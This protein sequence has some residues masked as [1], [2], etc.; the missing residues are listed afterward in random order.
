LI[1]PVDPRALPLD[2]TI[3][4]VITTYQSA[5][6]LVRALDSVERQT[7]RPTE[8]LVCDDGS[9]DETAS[10]ALARPGVRLLSLPHSGIVGISRNEGIAEATGEWIAF[11]DAD[12]E[13]VADHLKRFLDTLRRER[14]GFDLFGGNAVRVDAHEGESPL[15]IGRGRSSSGPVALEDFLRKRPIVTSSAVARR[16]AVLEAGGFAEEL[17]AVSAE[18]FDLWYRMV[19]RGG[20][21]FDDAA[22]V[23]YSVNEDGLTRQGGGLGSREA[24]IHVLRKNLAL[25]RA[26]GER[27]LLHRELVTD[28]IQLARA[29][30][31]LDRPATAVRS[32]TRVLREG[33]SAVARVA[34][35]AAVHRLRGA[36]RTALV[37]TVGASVLVSLLGLARQ[38]VLANIL[39]PTGIADLSLLLSI[40][41]P[42]STLALWPMLSF[43]GPLN[44][45][46]ETERRRYLKTAAMVCLLGFLA[47]AAL[48][49]I[50][51]YSTHVLHYPLGT[52]NGFNA[53]IVFAL[54]MVGIGY[55]TSAL[56]Y[57]GQLRRWRRIT[58]VVATAQLTLVVTAAWMWGRDGAVWSFASST[59]IIGAWLLLKPLVTSPR[60][61]FRLP[62]RWLAISLANGLVSM[63][64][65]G[66][67][68]TLRQASAAL[69]LTQ[70]AYFQASLSIIGAI[71]AGVAQY[72]GGRLLP[73]ATEA[74]T[75]GDHAIAWGEARRSLL[76]VTLFMILICGI[77]VLLAPALLTI[78][79]SSTFANAESLLR[80]I[81]LGESIVAVSTVVSTTLLG[82]GRTW[83][84]VALSIL[85]A[86]ARV[87]SYFILVDTSPRA[88][89]GGSYAI[90]GILAGVLALLS[91]RHF[92]RART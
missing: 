36:H 35:R 85:P 88:R 18:D 17:A 71:S 91:Y 47:A 60:S 80:L 73:V 92:A 86:V 32:A 38:K 54:G 53:T 87:A 4:A 9:T 28:Q 56:V 15:F 45:S 10:I 40:A 16:A 63:T 21:Y 69:S 3:S 14:A 23:R 90:G 34:T 72:T 39:G 42:L 76:V 37:L 33:P 48:A 79:F 25:T 70:A 77:L 78:G 62:K 24:A 83:A 8:V 58:V 2:A 30:W 12:D 75:R 43:V 65:I 1:A 26:R 13:W 68:A 6:T 84:W 7:V 46:D 44:A 89:L 81:V 52:R 5:R 29:L 64:L 22:H 82:L 11:L 66:V 31:K 49:S 50:L 57:S 61:G 55:A 74:R 27:R 20:I 59:G 41:L 67:E 19:G 51:A